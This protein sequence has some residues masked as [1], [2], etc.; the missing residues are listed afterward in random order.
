MFCS[1]SLLSNNSVTVE[2]V[3]DADDDTPDSESPVTGMWNALSL[4]L[5]PTWISERV[6]LESTHPETSPLTITPDASVCCTVS[7]IEKFPDTPDSWSW[8]VYASNLSIS[9]SPLILRLR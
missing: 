6:S 1:L 5:F 3:P 8:N 7:P 4:S 2:T 9:S